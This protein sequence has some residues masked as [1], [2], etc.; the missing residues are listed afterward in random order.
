MFEAG[1]KVV[2]VDD[3]PGSIPSDAQVEK[4]KIYVIESIA[5]ETA[6]QWAV[7]QLV[8][9]AGDWFVHRFRKLSDIQT[10][11]R[12]RRALRRSN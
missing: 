10:E 5:E 6:H 4:G 2:C 3:S 7:V 1:D 9:I 12:K 8:G 11:N